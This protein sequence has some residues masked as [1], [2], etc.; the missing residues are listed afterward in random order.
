MNRHAVAYPATGPAEG[1]YHLGAHAGA[2]VFQ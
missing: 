2:A 1:Y